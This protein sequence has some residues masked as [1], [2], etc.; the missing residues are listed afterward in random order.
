MKL[1]ITQQWLAKKLAHCDDADA[2]AGGTTIEELRKDVQRRTVTPEVLTAV[3]TELGKVVRFVREGQGWSLDDIAGLADVDVEE[4]SL[5]ETRSD[6]DPSP[7]TVS[8]LA[9]VCH[10]SKSKFIALARHK[11]VPMSDRGGVKFAA[12]SNRTDSIALS[13]FEIIQALVDTL[14]DGSDSNGSASA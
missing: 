5:I 4:V 14:S 13:E 2:A 8:R 11:D 9:D 12:R 10:F 1:V 6:Y 3:P 7:R